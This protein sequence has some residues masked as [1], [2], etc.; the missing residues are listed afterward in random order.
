MQRGVSCYCRTIPEGRKQYERQPCSKDPDD[1]AEAEDPDD[2]AE[3]EDPD[4]SAD[5][6]VK[7]GAVLL[8]GTGRHRGGPSRRRPHGVR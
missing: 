2:S 6:E 7:G 3:A 8:I 5:E 1:T 4:D